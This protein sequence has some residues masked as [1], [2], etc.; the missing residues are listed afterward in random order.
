MAS[1]LYRVSLFTLAIVAELRFV[2]ARSRPGS[3]VTPGR[4]G[5][6]PESLAF[7]CGSSF[8]AVLARFSLERPAATLAKSASSLVGR[9]FF[10]F[11]PCIASIF[12]FQRETSAWICGV[13][14]YSLGSEL[15]VCSLKPFS[16]ARSQCWVGEYSKTTSQNISRHT[17][18]QHLTVK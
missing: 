5:E 2:L 10:F 11:W 17:P 13:E 3:L 4:S 18:S 6:P 12:D 8:A 14:Y 9:A 7:R 15:R 1:S 16:H